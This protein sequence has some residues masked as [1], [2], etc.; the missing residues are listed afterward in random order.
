MKKL[1]LFLWR[2]NYFLSFFILFLFSFY[3]LVLYNQ[4]Q[5]TSYFTK[6][7]EVSGKY[8]SFKTNI[9]NYL[10]L[11]E[12]NNTLL[13]ENIYL[14]EN[15]I[16]SFLRRQKGN[17]LINDSVYNQQYTFI[18]CMVTKRT[19]YLTNNYLII[20]QGAKQ[21]IDI[22]MGV[23]T[24]EG[25]VGIIQHVSANF[26]SVLILINTKSNTPGYLKKANYNGRITWHPNEGD[27]TISLMDI[28]I[29]A[30]VSIGDTVTTG[31]SSILYPASIPVGIVKKVT[32]EPG[33]DFLKIEL[34]PSV[35]FKKINYVYVVNNLFKNEQKQ[36]E[37][38][39]KKELSE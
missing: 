15:N 1:F 20:D 5:H 39:T 32:K 19:T 4:Y 29:D 27:N 10:Q 6:Y 21:G 11:R 30:E 14:R 38:L 16:S 2:Y 35:N 33:E 36:L 17:I 22:E 34:T 24:S 37:E 8:N 26:S 13:L 18:P 12:T 3:L 7:Y 25:I 9:Y 23:I 28:P 31:N